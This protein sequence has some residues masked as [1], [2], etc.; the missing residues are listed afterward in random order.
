MRILFIAV[1]FAVDLGAQSRNLKYILSLQF[2]LILSKCEF[3]INTSLTLLY[4]LFI[5]LGQRPKKQHLVR[6]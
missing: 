2:S 5:S 6:A 1:I 4:C 3:N